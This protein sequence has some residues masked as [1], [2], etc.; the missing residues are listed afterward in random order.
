M[1]LIV[2]SRLSFSQRLQRSR[3]QKPKLP[4]PIPSALRPGPD[5]L[6]IAEFQDP[7]SL[8]PK[9]TPISVQ[10]FRS[11]LPQSRDLLILKWASGHFAALTVSRPNRHGV[12]LMAG[13]GG[14]I[15]ALEGRTTDRRTFVVTHLPSKLV[16]RLTCKISP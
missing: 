5:T 16:L 15:P 10:F 13:R 7:G 4:A 1:S 8:L 11:K 6:A 9:G 2:S 12:H 3:R 14:A